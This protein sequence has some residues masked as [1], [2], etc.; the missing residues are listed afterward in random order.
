MSL[1]SVSH[2]VRPGTPSAHRCQPRKEHLQLPLLQSQLLWLPLAHGVG[3]R[4]GLRELGGVWGPRPPHPGEP[5]SSS[6]RSI[7]ATENAGPEKA[8]NPTEPLIMG[9]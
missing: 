1:T 9:Q 8:N 4:A 7:L 6:D 3:S 2:V 5:S